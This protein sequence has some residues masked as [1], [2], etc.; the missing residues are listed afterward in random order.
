[1]PESC[2]KQPDNCSHIE[3]S[4]ISTKTEPDGEPIQGEVSHDVNH[5]LNWPLWQRQ[6]IAL[7]ISVLGFSGQLSSAL[8]NPAFKVMSLDLGVTVPQA[9]YLTTVFVLFGGV[10]PMFVVPF[11]NVYGRRILYVIFGAIAV[12]GNIG[13][14]AAPTYGGVFAGRVFNGIGSSIPL[15]LGPSTICDLFPQ[16]RRGLYMGIYV[17]LVNNGPHLAPIIGGFVTEKI[18]WRWCIWIPTIFQGCLWIITVLTL[19]ETL[20]SQNGENVSNRE[21]KSYLKKLLFHGKIVDRPIR[22]RDFGAS[23][24]MIKYGAVLLPCLYFGTAN[25]YGS[26][27]YAVTGAKITS[28]VFKFNTGQ[29]GMFMGIPLTVGCTIGEFGAGWV[30]DLIINNYAAR[31]NG[32]RKPEVRLWLLPLCSLLFIGTSVYGYCIENEKPWIMAAVACA[33]AG[34]GSQVATTVVYTYITDSYKPQSGEVGAVINL[35]KSLYAFNT[36][37]Y[38]LP[39]SEA[40]G[41]DAAFGLLAG[42]NAL[43]LLPLIYLIYG[44]ESLRAKQGIPSIQGE[45]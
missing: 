13:S 16:E 26:I 33:V 42:I 40:I 11:S 22:L 7:L 6:Y 43:T 21:K 15:G 29:T 30:S 4:Q 18:G 9:S 1:M 32:Y 44:G 3:G 2:E 19:P 41:Y 20:Y 24:R 28:E 35:I 12:A 27:L 31:H 45:L 8:I 5:P 37:F 36:G 34:V 38:A 25:T 14:A 17:L 23:F 10:V 39:L